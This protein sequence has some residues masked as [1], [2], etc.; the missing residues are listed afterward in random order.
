MLLTVLFAT[1]IIAAPV[2]GQ[3]STQTPTDNPQ[4]FQH[5]P[6]FVDEDGDGYNDNA[7]D[8]DG[9]GIPNGLDP[10]Y[11]NYRGE[12]WQGFVDEDGDGINDNVMQRHK[13]RGQRM[14]RGFGPGDG[15]G[16]QG[17]RP[18]DG[19]GYGAG[20]QGVGPA[21]GSNGNSNSGAQGSNG[22]KNRSKKGGKK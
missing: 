4:E 12:D 20:A 9:D 18:G 6:R 10:D 8:I 19:T 15:T 3:D 22:N 11:V 5:G 13:N 1:G 14:R 21:N 2:F 17:V 16:N 7:P